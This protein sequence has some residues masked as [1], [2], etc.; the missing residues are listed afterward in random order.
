VRLLDNVGV[1]HFGHGYFLEDGHEEEMS[2][3]EIW[4]YSRCR[5]SLSLLRI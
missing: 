5:C 4:G 2:L 3:K 1:H